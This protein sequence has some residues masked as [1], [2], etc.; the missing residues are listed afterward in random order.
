[1]RIK[2][3]SKKFTPGELLLARIQELALL[4]I[5]IA[6]G[7]L[8]EADPFSIFAV[9]AVVGLGSHFALER[10]SNR[11]LGQGIVVS[12]ILLGGLFLVRA[13]VEKNAA[14][15]NYQ[16][17]FDRALLKRH[18][19][20]VG[21]DGKLVIPWSAWAIYVYNP[22]DFTVHVSYVRRYGSINGVASP[23]NVDDQEALEIEPIPAGKSITCGSEVLYSPL[24]LGRTYRGDVSCVLKFGK[25][26]AR[27]DKTF[28]FTRKVEVTICPFA[29][30]I[31]ELGFY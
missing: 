18:V 22:N 15:D 9:A 10:A 20:Q 8:S 12:L 1:M 24:H 4:G 25:D 13:V 2:D 3:I 14:A 28:D 11:R 17:V 26:P 23:L 16:L 31:C 30:Q 7:W 29:N 21:K 5:A 6:L 27:L 19:G